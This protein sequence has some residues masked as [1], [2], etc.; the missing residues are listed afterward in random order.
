MAELTQG[1]TPPRK[2]YLEKY[3]TRFLDQAYLI[4]LYAA[5]YCDSKR[6]VSFKR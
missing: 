3:R 6:D 2:T 1:N 4:L 5:R